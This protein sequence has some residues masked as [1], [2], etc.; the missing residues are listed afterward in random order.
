MELLSLYI[1]DYRKMKRQGFHFSSKYIIEYEGLEDDLEIR[2]KFN[3]EYIQNFFGF[4]NI[5]S[6]TGII[7]QNGAGKT[8]TLD[9]IKNN[10]SN[11]ELDFEG[12][13]IVIIEKDDSDEYDGR[14]EK[15]R[16]YFPSHWNIK[17]SDDTNSFS[18]IPILNDKRKSLV[19]LD[20]IEAFEH[21]SIVFY[22]N[23]FDGKEER[24]REGCFDI[25]TN[26]LLRK[27]YKRYADIKQVDAFNDSEL[28][29][30]LLFIAS[31]KPEKKLPF[32]L[33]ESLYVSILR[34]DQYSLKEA[35]GE[36]GL[37]K[38]YNAYSNTSYLY[39]RSSSY[40]DL[41][42]TELFVAAFFNFIRSDF[43]FMAQPILKESFAKVSLENIKDAIAYF[44]YNISRNKEHPYSTHAII[45]L[46]FLEYAVELITRKILYIG[47]QLPSY[48]L[49]LKDYR[50]ESELFINKYNKAKTFTNF[51]KFDWSDLSSGQK[52]LLNLFSRFYSL[53]DEINPESNRLKS[54]ILILL[55]EGDLYFHP[56]WQRRFFR[57]VLDF[58]ASLFPNKKIQIVL[59]SNSPF[60]ASDLPKSNV[61]FINKDREVLPSIN[62]REETFA[63]N[64]HTLFADSFFMD[65]ALIGEFAKSKIDEIIDYL[66]NAQY[67]TELNEKYRAIVNIIGEPIIKYKIEELWI[68]KMGREE[69]IKILQNRINQLQNRTDD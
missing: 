27:D 67:D 48:P 46:E 15:K 69:E 44:F 68:E 29:R 28:L 35:F 7:G 19:Q 32:K 33:P 55:D 6:V 22:S 47:G 62:S 53:A 37:I 39:K 31:E 50:T 24:E 49:N 63:S 60:L 5:K 34:D 9:F 4:A 23:I 1:T 25:S 40:E 3:P 58:L 17:I 57:T 61:I 21:V 20:S 16:I 10:L 51:L 13:S 18:A 66:Q 59:A 41:F 45:I 8:S 52:S 36:F 12:Y 2:I 38:I 26:S 30:Q 54:S 64:I 56:E 42:I 43:E 65:E 14:P 11:G